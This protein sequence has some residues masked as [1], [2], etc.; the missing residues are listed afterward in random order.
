VLL[1]ESKENNYFMKN[2][3]FLVLLFFVL[4][5]SAMLV[6]Q[7]QE[8]AKITVKKESNLVK[9]ILDNNELKLIA[10]DKYG[11]IHPHSIKSFELHYEVKKKKLKVL[12]SSSAFLT[13]E[14]INDLHGLQ[15]AK[16]IFYTKIVAEDQNGNLVNLPDVIEMHFPR[17][18]NLK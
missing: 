14:M 8:I 12:R 3:R 18:K 9:A 2:N 5:F 11:N 17:C 15:E 6:A 7:D 1:I 4:L 16:K 10:Q 13:N